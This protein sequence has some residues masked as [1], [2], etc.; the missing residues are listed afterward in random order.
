MFNVGFDCVLSIQSFSLFCLPLLWLAVLSSWKSKRL[1]KWNQASFELVQPSHSP[2][3][4]P[5]FAASDLIETLVVPSCRLTRLSAISK[6]QPYRIRASIS[7]KEP[8]AAT[9]QPDHCFDQVPGDSIAAMIKIWPV[10]L[11]VIL[12][13]HHVVAMA[14]ER[15]R[16]LDIVEATWRCRLAALIVELT[17]SARVLNIK[18]SSERLPTQWALS[19]CALRLFLNL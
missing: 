5:R 7:P 10:F 9:Q 19:C 15:P 4:C 8:E 18:V 14:E 11:Q 6:V 3:C 1:G 2:T 17:Q 13:H 12:G 16:H